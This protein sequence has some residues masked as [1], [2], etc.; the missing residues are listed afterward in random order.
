MSETV[1]V[2][3]LQV[4]PETGEV[5]EEP[6]TIEAMIAATMT[7]DEG[8][9]EGE[10]E[11]IETDGEGEHVEGD[12]AEMEGYLTAEEAERQAA[13]HAELRA[14]MKAQEKAFKARDTRVD[15]FTKYMEQWAVEQEQPLVRCPVCI[16]ETPGFIFHPAHVQLTQDQLNACN[17]L[18]GNPLEPELEQMPGARQCPVCKGKGNGWTGSE[19]TNRR[20]ITCPEC[21]GDGW[22]GE[23]KNLKPEQAAAPQY[24]Q[25]TEDGRPP[26]EL[27]K[28][29][30]WGTPDWDPDF[31][32]MPQ[33]REPGWDNGTGVWV[34]PDQR[35]S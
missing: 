1:E 24:I 27:P 35:V 4:D 8:D 9:A 19:V 12:E 7:P 6:T 14:S 21:K 22:V 3:G 31:Y 34:H 2:D 5:I 16:P 32:K 11:P 30:P 29:D 13:E 25:P 28:L 23:A 20:T 10:P 17:I 18:A 26:E 15:T 33:G